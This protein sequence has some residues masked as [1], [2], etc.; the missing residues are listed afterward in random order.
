ME[1]VDAPYKSMLADADYFSL[2]MQEYMSMK[3]ASEKTHAK[4]KRNAPSII[5]LLTLLDI[6]FAMFRDA[7]LCVVYDLYEAVKNHPTVDFD[8]V[9]AWTVCCF[10]A[11]PSRQCLSV[12]RMTVHAQYLK[13][14]QCLWLATHMHEVVGARRAGDAPGSAAQGATPALQS[15]LFRKAFCFIFQELELLYGRA[16]RQFCPMQAP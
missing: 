9:D 12:G 3:S 5:G 2:E 16:A 4:C 7:G 15:E 13:L 8:T 6:V 14:L 10:S 1:C 11:L